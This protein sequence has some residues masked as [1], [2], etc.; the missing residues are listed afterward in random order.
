[1]RRFPGVE[2]PSSVLFASSMSRNAPPTSVEFYRHRRRQ[3]QRI[4]RANED[5]STRDLRRNK[6][7]NARKSARDLLTDSDRGEIR[8]LDTDARRTARD[9]L[10][11]SPRA[12]IRQRDTAA[13]RSARLNPADKPWW[14]RVAVL[15]SSQEIEPVGLRWN[16]KC[17]HCGI[18]V[19]DR[20]FNRMTF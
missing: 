1:M 14:D 17:K 8:H 6:D 10:D 15:N 7:A 20:Y 9:N 5:N 4:R 13:H 19:C 2:R 3:Q 18:T 11:N 12:E 16:K